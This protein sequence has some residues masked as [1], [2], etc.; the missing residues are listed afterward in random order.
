MLI[1]DNHDMEPVVSGVADP[2]QQ[3]GNDVLQP[4][5]GI[6]QMLYGTELAM[7]NP[8]TKAASSWSDRVVLMTATTLSSVD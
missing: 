4:L 3:D 2:D 8:P 5:R 7:S 1:A 6:P